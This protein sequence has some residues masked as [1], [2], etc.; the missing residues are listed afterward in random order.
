MPRFSVCVLALF[1]SSQASAASILTNGSFEMPALSAGSYLGVGTGSALGPAGGWT[2]QGA[3]GQV[4]VVDGAFTAGGFTFPA[5]HDMQWVDLTGDNS[6]TATGVQ[7]VFP[8]TIGGTYDLT[9]QVG[10]VVDTTGSLGTSSAVRVLVNNVDRGTVTNTDGAGSTEMVWREFKVT[11]T[12]T[13]GTTTIRLVNADGATDNLNGLDNVVVK[14]RGAPSAGGGA[15]GL[16]LLLLL[17][18]AGLRRRRL[19]K[20]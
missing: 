19:H 11:F 9:F 18:L 17:G 7:Q 10:N 8:T 4:S 14:R 12:A 5:Q 20:P 16:P 15:A 1:L 6:N 2:V 13:A 3:S